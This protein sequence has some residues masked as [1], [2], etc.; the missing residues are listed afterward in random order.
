[1]ATPGPKRMLSESETLTAVKKHHDPFVTARD[2]AEKA[3]IARQTAY[4]YLQQLHEK[5]QI[6]KK[7]VGGS[8]A[9]WWLD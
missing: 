1:M 6:H 4:R 5:G 9:I 3:G 7:K 8:A 2:V